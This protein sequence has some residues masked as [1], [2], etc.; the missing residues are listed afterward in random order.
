MKCCY[1]KTS[2]WLF[3]KFVSKFTFIMATL[4]RTSPVSQELFKSA[5]TLTSRKSA[6]TWVTHQVGPGKFTLKH[7]A[8]PMTSCPMAKISKYFSFHSLKLESGGA[9]QRQ[10]AGCESA[11]LLRGSTI[12]GSVQVHGCVIVM[13]SGQ[14]AEALQRSK[15]QFGQLRLGWVRNP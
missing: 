13:A 9:V 5:S 14:A 12:S 10:K 6:L 7:F 15:M 11:L 4:H 3:F 8:S 2:V 1:Y